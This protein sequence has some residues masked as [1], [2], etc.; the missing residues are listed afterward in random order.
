MPRRILILLGVLLASGV[1]WFAFRPAP[2]ARPLV[3]HG[4]VD[5]RQVDLSFKDSERIAC[6]RV[7]EGDA[8]APGDVVATLETSRLD[9]DI[10]RARSVVRAQEAVVARLEAGSRVQEI[11]RAE[12]DAEA[13][14][15]AAVNA[16]ATHRRM[17]ELLAS[18]GVAPQDE[19][20]A[21]TARDVAEAQA[22]QTRA[23][24]ALVREGPRLEDI[25]EAKAALQARREEVAVLERRRVESVLT[26]P[27][28]GVVRKRLLEP[29]D[30]AGPS[31]PVCT[32]DLTGMKWVRVFVP[33]TLLTRMQPGR[34]VHVSVDGVPGRGFAGRVGHVASSAE[35]TPRNVETPELRTSLVYEVRILVDDPDNLL[36]LGM[37]AT[38]GF[39]AG[40]AAGG[41]S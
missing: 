40:P 9:L 23:Q 21:R 39:E 26:A 27:S 7:D 41:G 32:L 16:R 6:V 12:A 31:R 2:G 17:A 38:V 35:F 1:A 18:G 29:G 4:N 15:A 24:L 10:A 3:L 36:R 19:E 34:P 5:H 20:N 11:R 14:R 37:P 25:A 28:A 13:A 22:A 30:M 8:L 33:E